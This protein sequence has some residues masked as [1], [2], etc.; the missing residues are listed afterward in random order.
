MRRLGIWIEKDGAE[1][2]LV[3]PRFYEV[4]L[5]GGEKELRLD[6][7]KEE[8]A[9]GGGKEEEESL[10]SFLIFLPSFHIFSPP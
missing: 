7:L 4:G 6:G 8:G 5:G 9:G 3:R 1:G 10:V 2:S